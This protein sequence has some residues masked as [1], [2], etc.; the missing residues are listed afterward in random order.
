MSHIIA[1]YDV[2]D[3][4]DEARVAAVEDGPLSVERRDYFMCRYG[5]WMI[6]WSHSAAMP[7]LLL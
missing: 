4:L 3:W 6:R 2:V 1:N 7:R 5:S